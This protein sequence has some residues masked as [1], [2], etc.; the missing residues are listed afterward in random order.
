MARALE[1]SWNVFPPLPLSFA[2][3]WSARNFV[4]LDPD[5]GGQGPSDWRGEE[6]TIGSGGGNDDDKPNGEDWS[7]Y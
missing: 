5:N 3:S 4:N 7:E 6:G 2:L 1:Q